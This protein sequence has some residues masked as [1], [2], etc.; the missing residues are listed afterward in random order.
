MPTDVFINGNKAG[1]VPDHL[2]KTIFFDTPDQESRFSLEL[3]NRRR[4]DLGHTCQLNRRTGD[5]LDGPGKR[6][7]TEALATVSDESQ[8]ANFQHEW[9]GGITFSLYWRQ[10]RK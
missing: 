6:E 2:G 10:A 3:K 8:V 5:L 1:T 7:I 4:N 9:T